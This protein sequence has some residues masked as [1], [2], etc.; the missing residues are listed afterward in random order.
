MLFAYLY[1]TPKGLVVGFAYGLLQLIQDLYVIHWAQLILDYGLSFMSL[2]LAGLFRKNLF[3]GV[4]TAG[5]ARYVVHVISGAIFFGSYAA[6]GQTALVYS[7]GYNIYVLIDV[8]I[9]LVV[10]LIPPFRKFIN[11]VK[12][13]GQLA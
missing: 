4:L 13:Q 12:A 3:A 8:A 6:P 9:C 10:V 2:A 11:R 1:G 5:I 7:L